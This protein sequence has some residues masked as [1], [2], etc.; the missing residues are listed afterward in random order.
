MRGLFTLKKVFADLA[1]NLDLTLS[2]STLKRACK[3]AGLSWKRVRKFLKSKRNPDLLEQSQQQLLS[4]IE[5][6]QKGE[7]DLFSKLLVKTMHFSAR[8]IVMS[9]L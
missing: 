9:F 4:L 3:R 5:Q 2:L 6:L 7:I 8:L 1:G